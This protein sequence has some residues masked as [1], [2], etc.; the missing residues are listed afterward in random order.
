MTTQLTLPFDHGIPFEILDIQPDPA[1]AQ[2]RLAQAH[3]ICEHF[4]RDK[5]KQLAAIRKMLESDWKSVPSR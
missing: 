5:V 3:A 4:R 2:E 1:K